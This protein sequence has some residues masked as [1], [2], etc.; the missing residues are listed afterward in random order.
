MAPWQQALMDRCGGGT[1]SSLRGMASMVG[2]G[3]VCLSSTVAC[4]VLSIGIPII[5]PVVKA[6]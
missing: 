3:R 6:D 2:G 1:R 4:T 5:V